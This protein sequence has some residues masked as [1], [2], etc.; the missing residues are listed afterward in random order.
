MQGL[1]LGST[2]QEIDRKIP[3][4]EYHR[5]AMSLVGKTQSLIISEGNSD[6]ADCQELVLI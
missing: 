6:T 4:S 3:V 2:P 1:Q 5:L